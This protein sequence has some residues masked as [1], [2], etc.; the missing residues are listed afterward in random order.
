MSEVV[1]KLTAVESRLDTIADLLSQA[2]SSSE[3]KRQELDEERKQDE[4][5]LRRERLVR[6]KRL[7]QEEKMLG[8]R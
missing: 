4:E 3:E 6:E 2:L 8:L 5:L 7:E 1:E